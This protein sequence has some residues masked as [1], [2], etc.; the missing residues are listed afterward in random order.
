MGGS[1]SSLAEG[2]LTGRG[3]HRNHKSAQRT[4]AVV[5]TTTELQLPLIRWIHMPLW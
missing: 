1:G 4:A 3:L 2:G 5:I